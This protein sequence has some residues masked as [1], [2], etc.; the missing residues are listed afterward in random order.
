MFLS[1]F[2]HIISTYG[3][4]SATEIYINTLV[5]YKKIK[6]LYSQNMAMEMEFSKENNK[7]ELNMTSSS[8]SY[9]CSN[10]YFHCFPSKF[11]LPSPPPPTS[12]LPEDGSKVAS[13]QRRKPGGWK[14][15]PFVLGN[16]TFERLASM[17][18]IANFMVFLLTQLHM[19]QVLASNVLNIWSGVSNFAPLVGAFI[20]DAYTGR[21]TTIAFASFASFMGMLTLTIIAWL[22]QLHPPSCNV[23]QSPNSCQGPTKFQFGILAVALAFL[24]VGSGGIRPCSI[25]FGVDQFDGGTDQGRKGINSFFNWYYTTFTLVMIIALTL[26]VYVQ[27]SVS[28]VWGFGLLTA[29]MAASISLFF[30]GTR[31]YVYV[32]PEGSVFSGIAHVVVAAYKKRK[33]NVDGTYYDPP[34]AKGTFAEKLHLTNKCR[35]LN[36]A[37]IIAE[38]DVQPNGSISN[39]WRLCS[40]HQIEEFKCIIKIIPIWASGIICFTAIAQQGTFTMSQASKMDRRLTSSFKIPQGT[41][42]VISM[43][44]VGIWVPIYDRLVVPS[45]RKV[46]KL[47]GGITLLQRMGIGLV[48]SVMSMVVAGLVERMRRDSAVLHHSLDGVAPMTVFWLA[49]QL[50]LMG[51]AEAFNIIGQ[52][53]FYNKEFPETM[54]SLANSLFS[55]TMAGASYLSALIVNV[56][57]K[58]TGRKGRPD[59]LTKDINAGKVENFYFLIAGLGVLNLVYFLWVSRGYQYKSRMR[60]GSDGESDEV[61]KPKLDV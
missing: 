25:P 18:L 31:L 41:L 19:D 24:S 2:R 48:F 9:L 3:A 10:K 21:F 8:F 40:V 12:S 27:D 53:E 16:E 51:F 1:F 26:V 29:F 61:E 38:G 46:T 32:K 7:E 6:Q 43:I 35:F 42:I 23:L 28:W 55:C 5:L 57:H 11:L 60:I 39:P 37:A 45:I 54:T 49:P 52:I 59:W 47:E 34:V 20:S 56:V 4:S 44:T 13:L 33:R 30:A 50:I 15:M 36:K 58:S 17:G 22:P 14:A